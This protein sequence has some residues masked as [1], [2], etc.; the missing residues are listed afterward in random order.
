M[1][2]FLTELTRLAH[3]HPNKMAIVDETSSI[4]FAELVILIKKTNGFLVDLGIK[5]NDVVGIH[6]KNEKDH[7]ILSL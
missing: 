7:L 4:N 6:I 1:T 5:R 2:S 3:A